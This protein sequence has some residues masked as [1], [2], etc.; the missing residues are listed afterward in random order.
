MSFAYYD[1][2]TDQMMSANLSPAF[3][4]F[5]DSKGYI[6]NLDEKLGQGGAAVAFQGTRKED[7]TPV[8]LVITPWD[9]RSLTWFEQ[10]YSTTK[11]ITDQMTGVAHLFD[12]MFFDGAITTDSVLSPEL[13][14]HPTSVQVMELLP[15]TLAEYMYT[16]VRHESLAFKAMFIIDIYKQLRVILENLATLGLTYTDLIP[17]NIGFTNDKNCVMIDLEAI[18]NIEYEYSVENTLFYVIKE[19]C[20]LPHLGEDESVLAERK[21]WKLVGGICNDLTESTEL[22]RALKRY[23]N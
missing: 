12:Y 2:D 9:T 11:A 13:K 4:S 14:T 5:L 16:T 15:R 8:A 1:E 20:S 18:Q 10:L 7:N 17:D 3:V 21:E 22:L 19:I 23:I 6:I